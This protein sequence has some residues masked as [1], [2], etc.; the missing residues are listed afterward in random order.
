MY[1]KSIEHNEE[2]WA[3]HGKRI[4]WIKPYTKI[5]DCSFDENDLHIK[6]YY[7]GTLNISYNCID[8]HIKNGKGDQTAIIW[9][10]NHVDK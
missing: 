9:E 5:K 10:G 4:D 8:R 3:E 6:W 1:K 2:F 7:D